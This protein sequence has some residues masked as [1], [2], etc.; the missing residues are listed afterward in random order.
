MVGGN[1]AVLRVGERSRLD[2][3]AL[4]G[5]FS[6]FGGG[7][8]VG[9]GRMWGEAMEGEEREEG[10]EGDGGGGG[11]GGVAE[12]GRARVRSQRLMNSSIFFTF[13]FLFS[14]FYH[15]SQV[16]GEV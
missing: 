2:G 15:C 12:I 10:K 14:F 16:P 5:K 6:M 4:L 9:R 13:F 3:L 7:L 1:C 11:G 8:E